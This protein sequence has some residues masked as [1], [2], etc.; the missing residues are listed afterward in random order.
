MTIRLAT[1]DDAEQLQALYAPYVKNTAIT[2]EIY[3]PSVEEFE[4]RIKSVLKFYPYF[5]EERDGKILGFTYATRF[6]ERAGYDWSI[7]TSVYVDRNN[8]G[9]GIGGMLH[10][11]LEEALKKQHIL[12]MCACIAAPRGKNPYLTDSSIGFHKHLGYRMVGRFEY[13]AYKFDTWFDMVWMEK[14]I[15]KHEDGNVTPI[16]PYWKVS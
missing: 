12:N 3:P 14:H 10:D 2:F 5:V 1:P 8:R 9:S 6:N 13:S 4:R 16:V 7:E 15:G 11:A